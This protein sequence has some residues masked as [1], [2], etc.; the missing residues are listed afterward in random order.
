[1]MVTAADADF[2]LSAAEVAVNVTCAG[3]GTELGAV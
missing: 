2:V 1:M 3:L